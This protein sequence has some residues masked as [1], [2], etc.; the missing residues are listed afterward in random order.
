MA[1]AGAV[2]PHPLASTATAEAG[3]AAEAEAVAAAA[4][5]VAAAVSTM[6]YDVRTPQLRPMRPS[7]EARVEVALAW[8]VSV[9]GTGWTKV[10][11]GA[12]RSHPITGGGEVYPHRMLRTT[13]AP[14]RVLREGRR[15]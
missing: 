8:P 2:C 14:T 7:V 9:W 1:E 13:I 3:V 15:L 10:L 4:V 5:A 12:A 11:A 6:E